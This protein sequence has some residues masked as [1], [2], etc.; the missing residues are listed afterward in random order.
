[1]FINFALKFYLYQFIEIHGMKNM[2]SE[3]RSLAPQVILDKLH[4]LMSFV[5]IPFYIV[6]V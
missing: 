6:R 4:H 3:A 2:S 1:M 5:N